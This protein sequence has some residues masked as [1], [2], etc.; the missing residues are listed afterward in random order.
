MLI[1][2]QT[3]VA[4]LASYQRKNLEKE[5]RSPP[6][7]FTITIEKGVAKMICDHCSNEITNRGDDKVVFFNMEDICNKCWQV[8]IQI[9]AS[10]TIRGRPLFTGADINGAARS[11]Y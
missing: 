7:G 5:P 4:V 1:P 6:L 11:G 3:R 9:T 8:M 2:E 10:E